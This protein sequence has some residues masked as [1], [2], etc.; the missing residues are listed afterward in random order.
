MAYGLGRVH[1]IGDAVF[2]RHR[3]D[4]GGGID[5]P[6]LAGSQVS[7]IRRTRSSSMARSLGIDAAVLV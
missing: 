3:A 4:R 5:Q 2:A 6:P 7:A 1:E